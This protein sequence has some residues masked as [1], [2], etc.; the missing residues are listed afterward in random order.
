MARELDQ[1]TR[2]LRLP[3]AFDVE[4]LRADL[5]IATAWHWQTHYNDRAHRGSWTSIA[6]RSAS[7]EAGDI[8]AWE[9]ADFRDSPLLARC[10]GFREAVDSFACEKKAVRL[11]A[12][13]PGAEIMPH[14]DRGGSLEDGLARLHI[15]IVTDPAVVFTLDGE[16]VHFSAGATWYMN[17]NC[18]HAVRNG[19]TRERVHLVLDCVPN[20][21]LLALFEASGWRPAPPPKYGDPN[22]D[23]A[24]VGAVIA[25]LRASG[26]P[27]AEALAAQLETASSDRYGKTAPMLG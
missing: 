10:P 15:P 17:A 16:E 9:G 11:M 2:W 1:A 3:L 6:L 4:G 22:I 27:A 13:A 23:D 12:L 21:W 19:S 18:L 20:A 26:N 7:G 8:Q 24:N 14:R 25:A 5:G